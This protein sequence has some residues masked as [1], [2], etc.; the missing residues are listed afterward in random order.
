MKRLFWV[1]LVAA[2]LLSGLVLSGWQN[3][4]GTLAKTQS[5]RDPRTQ[6]DAKAYTRAP[7]RHV[8][9]DML[10]KQVMDMNQKAATER[11]SGQSVATF[12]TMRQS[13]KRYLNLTDAQDMILD[14]IAADC[15]R[16][17]D[18]IDQ[19]AKEIISS[20]W[21]KYPPGTVFTEENRPKAPKEL[22]ELQDKHDDVVLKYRDQLRQQLGDTGFENFE[23]ALYRNFGSKITTVP[24]APRKIE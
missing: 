6:I 17:A 8:V 19:Q 10:F 11:A 24:V 16:E 12:Q 18:L 3:K 15:A 21:A 9:Y 23:S 5:Q 4:D 14:N 20:F 2:V 13:F 7:E 22:E 1:A